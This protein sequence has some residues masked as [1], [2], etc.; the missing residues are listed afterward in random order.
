VKQ[1]VKLEIRYLNDVALTSIELPKTVLG[2]G[3]S[4]SINVTAA[5]QGDQ[6][7]TFNVT[8]R[9]N[10]TIVGMS[11]VSLASG[12]STVVTFIWNTTGS[13]KG[14]YTVSGYIT[15]VAGETDTDDNNFTD[16][17]VFV[18]MVGDLTCDGFVDIVDVAMVA[19]A[20][21]SPGAHPERYDPIL[22]I[23]DDGFIDIVDIATVAYEFG[24]VD[25]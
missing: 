18:A 15:P 20:F 6:I 11:E 19:Y 2:L 17:W 13:A 24:K 22:D 8:L 12:S 1:V 4:M 7:E 5:N 25:P 16:G 9:V 10:A 23:N 21:G 14:N 3:F